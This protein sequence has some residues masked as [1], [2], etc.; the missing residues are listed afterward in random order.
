MEIRDDRC[1]SCLSVCN[2]GDKLPELL[3]CGYLVGDK[4]DITV[5]LSGKDDAISEKGKEEYLYS[6]FYILCISQS[7]RAWIT[8]FYLQIHYACLSFVCV[9]QMAP[10]LTD[11]R[12]I[13]LQLTTDLSPP[14]RDERLRWPGWL[15]Y[16]GRFT[17]IS[18]H[19]S[20]AGRAQDR[21]S[22]LAED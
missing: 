19:L 6:A 10:F 12:D 13:Q 3:P 8:Q 5:S 20:A 9:Y 4:Q 2:R 21:E 18:G 7:A 1:L 22:S 17:H 14:H 15:T 11:V 16:S